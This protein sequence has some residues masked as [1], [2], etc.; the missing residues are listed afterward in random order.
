MEK[1]IDMLFHEHPDFKE[2]VK[3]CTEKEIDKLA[4]LVHI[5]IPNDY[6]TFLKYMG[7]DTGRVYGSR[8]KYG[9]NEPA[10]NTR[11]MNM[12]IRIDYNSVLTFYKEIHKRK[13]YGF[14]KLPEDHEGRAEDFFLFGIDC[15]G[16]DNGNFYLD[17]RSPDLPV[18]E[19]SSTIPI[20]QRCPSFRKFLF[21]IPFRRTL[22]K[23]EY[24]KQWL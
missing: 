17:L 21:D 23:Y 5:S 24:S 11:F 22:S 9:T 10:E 7:N 19:I 13:L 16:N 2:E 3:G 15:L 14:F 6:V 20:V 8:R 12:K 4:K 1:L 18:V